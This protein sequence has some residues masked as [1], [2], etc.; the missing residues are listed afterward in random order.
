MVDSGLMFCH[1]CFSPLC[2]TLLLASGRRAQGNG[3]TS[4]QGRDL[5]LPEVLTMSPDR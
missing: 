1:G 3:A 5:R 4:I 2:I